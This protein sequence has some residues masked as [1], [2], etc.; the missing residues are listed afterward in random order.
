[1]LLKLALSLLNIT[2]EEYLKLPNYIPILC[3]NGDV[4]L[5]HPGGINHIAYSIKD[6]EQYGSITEIQVKD[7]D[8]LHLDFR[9]VVDND[10]L[11]CPTYSRDGRGRRAI[12][13]SLFFDAELEISDE[14]CIPKHYLPTDR[15]CS[16]GHLP[17]MDLFRELKHSPSSEDLIKQILTYMGADTMTSNTSKTSVVSTTV[18]T[19]VDSNKASMITAAKLEV[20]SLAIN[21]VTEQLL[22]LLPPPA[23][24]L[25]KDNPLLKVAVA[26]LVQVL[27]SAIPVDD[28]RV[29][30][31]VDS[32]MT[33]SY[34]ELLN[35][36]D[37][38]SIVTDML[39]KLP[40][41]KLTTLTSATQ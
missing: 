37:L 1:M 24:M 33:A 25:L 7:F 15:V 29:G 28:A 22:K 20:G 13:G 23:T 17:V 19:L 12:Q 31:V 30:V 3:D 9:K 39:D 36:F 11:N 32:M 34:I 5:L 38:Q 10:S 4:A 26:N 16:Q 6:Y 41:S 40:K 8:R 35:S 14:Y 2:V 18:S 21:L 27:S